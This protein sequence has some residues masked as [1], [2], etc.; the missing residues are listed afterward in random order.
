MAPVAA[1][2][3]E[4]ELILAAGVVAP[5]QGVGAVGE[6]EDEDSSVALGALEESERAILVGN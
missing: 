6:A 1:V 4:L 3:E 2:G 5:K